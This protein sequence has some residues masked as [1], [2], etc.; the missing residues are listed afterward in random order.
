M[1]LA[2]PPLGRSANRYNG[3]GGAGRLRSAA[4]R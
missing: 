1:R 3:L 2:H 4:V